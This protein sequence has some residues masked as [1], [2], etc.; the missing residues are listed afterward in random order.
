MA[1]YRTH[2]AAMR[3]EREAEASA[4]SAGHAREA[5]PD[6]VPADMLAGAADAASGA[7]LP[8]APAEAMDAA[9]AEIR[10]ADAGPPDTGS[11]DA[12]PADAGSADAGPATETSP[13]VQPAAPRPPAAPISD[14]AAALHAALARAFPPE[15][16][17]TPEQW[18]HGSSGQG[19]S[20]HGHSRHGQSR[21]GQSQQGQARPVPAGAAALGHENVMTAGS[22]P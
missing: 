10:P 11:A 2:L 6:G 17:G 19:R 8:A 12:G 4:A 1:G 18:P 22:A 21:H 7:V 20:R 3:A 9:S 5:R 16:V 15:P 14:R 13:A